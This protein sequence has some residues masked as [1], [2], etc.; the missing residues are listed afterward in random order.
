[1]ST[2][3]L[4]RRYFIELKKVTDLLKDLTKRILIPQ[5][6]NI[7]AQARAVRPVADSARLD[8]FSDEVEKIL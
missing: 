6:G 3:S 7:A 8:D 5:I 2:K 4:E 1:M